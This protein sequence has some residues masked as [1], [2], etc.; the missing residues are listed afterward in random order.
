[1]PAGRPKIV[2][3]YKKVARLA[4]VQYTQQKIADYLGVSLRTLQRDDKFCHI[5]KQKKEDKKI[6]LL[7]SQFVLAE[8][9][10]TMSI[11]LGK[12]Y[13]NQRDPDKSLT[14][15]TDDVGNKLGKIAD[16]ISKQDTIENKQV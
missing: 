6:E 1:M 8:K 2:I 9:N 14:Q 3:D 11:W 10:P 4:S 13:L 7:E 15:I 16:A 5:Y 12:N